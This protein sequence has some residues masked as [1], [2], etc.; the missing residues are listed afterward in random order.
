M[1]GRGAELASLREAAGALGPGGAAL[2][3]E[4]PPGIGKSTLAD[5]F[6]AELVADG[7]TLLRC[8]GLEGEAAPGFAGL[9]EL[10]HPVL[11]HL[12]VLPERQA[13]ALRAAF[14]MVDG[15]VSDQLLIGLATLGLV[16]EAA[17]NRRL[18]LVVEDAQWLD[19]SSLSA[20]LFVARRLGRARALMLLSVRTGT[21]A[22]DPLRGQPVRRLTLRPLDA[23]ESRRLV[24][25]R[26]PDLPD[27]QVGQVLAEAAG[28]PL[29]LVEFAAAVAAH[30]LP[31][32]RPLVPQLPT[33]RRLEA[34]FLTGV[35]SLPPASR[36]LLLLAAAGTRPTVAELLLAG[37]AGEADLGPIE[38]A[39]LAEVVGGRLTFRHPLVRSAVYNAA[40]SSERASAHRTLAEVAPDPEQAA[41]HRASATHDRDEAVAAELEAAAEP[42]RR[43]GALAEAVTALRRAAALSPDLADRVRRL[44]VAAELARQAGRVAEAS[45]LL[46]QALPLVS[47]VD[48]LTLLNGTEVLLAVTTDTPTRSP[49]EALGLVDRIGPE[50]RP[51]RSAIVLSACTRAWW[52]G[53]P[54]PVLAALDRA[55]RRLPDGGDDWLALLC[56]AFTDPAAVAGELR[57]RLPRFVAAVRSEPLPGD[58]GE[59]GAPRWF[60]PVGLAA[61]ALH[62]LETA[63][64]TW[65]ASVESARA[66][67]AA[68]DEA[69]TVARRGLTRALAGD[70]AGAAADGD[71]ASRLAAQLELAPVVGLGTAVT[72]LAAALEGRPAEA[73]HAVQRS[74]AS[75]DRTPTAVVAATAHWAAGLVALEE[76]RAADAFHELS[77]VRVHPAL[78]WWAL[79]D[80]VEAAV[81]AGRAAE[82][83][84]RVAEAGQLARALG[85][86][87]LAVLV[88]RCRGL[89]DQGA[90]AGDHHERSI[91][92][93]GTTAS[94]L[95]LARTRLAYGEWLR[96]HRRISGA[97]DQL[98]R[99]E[100]AFRTAGARNLAD[101]ATAELR[102]AGAGV[103]A[104]AGPA[105]GSH[106][107]R[108]LTP[109]ER[110]I[111]ELA[112]SGMTNPE[113]AD[114]LYLSPRTVGYHLFKAFPKLG[115]TKRTQLVDV[116]RGAS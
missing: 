23:D 80:L 100:E 37:R 79:G 8:T 26:Y 103:A 63:L 109:Q 45:S 47:D 18:L 99:A 30:G 53:A 97:R 1:I 54:A 70:L 105:A 48:V 22:V 69:L 44:A 16:E 91:A 3:I 11:D 19:G 110:Q 92:A 67:G 31:A 98:R 73:T 38:R 55:A 60:Y 116:L 40:S 5:A 85:S 83:A 7:F 114:H 82:V 49:E 29:A 108:S 6:A 52:V 57:S 96:R 88:H 41:W 42:A 17:A 4:G 34:A 77:S 20:L 72:A 94:P 32:E 12:G 101:R 21:S 9:H 65:D 90:D 50:H 89:L 71:H 15:A 46:R 78:A 66:T 104:E 93:G 39:G 107:L 35:D 102:A 58:V 10:L 64:G 95:E 25:E 68:A 2:V 13:A 106:P 61:L 81:R 28:N 111:V 112:A 84:S 43:R 56:R 115:V 75:V 74:R 86:P 76:G 62:D 113:I 87:H 36:R 24:R 14:G 59:S 27:R 51:Q 33:S